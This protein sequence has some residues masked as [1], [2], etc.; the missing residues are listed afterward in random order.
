MDSQALYDKFRMRF[1][2]GEWKLGQRIPSIRQVVTSEGAS[3][4]TVVKLYERL[5]AEGYIEAQ[6]GRGYFVTRSGSDG[7]AVTVP[8]GAKGRSAPPVRS[9]SPETARSAA[10]SPST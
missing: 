9:S 8:F 2:N 4:H 5:V 1:D 7:S 10:V 6:Q 3:H